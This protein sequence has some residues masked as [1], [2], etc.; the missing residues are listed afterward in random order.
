MLLEKIKIIF[1]DVTDVY[2]MKKILKI[3]T[4]SLLLSFI[5]AFRATDTIIEKL[6]S[7]IFGLFSIL[8][9]VEIAFFGLFFAESIVNRKAKEFIVNKEE[10]I[11]YYQ[12]LVTKNFYSISL[13]MTNI[14]VIYI[15]QIFDLKFSVHDTVITFL[16]K[17]FPIKLGAY[18]FFYFLS[19]YTLIVMVDLI[20]TIYFYLWK[21]EKQP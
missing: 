17:V 20:V 11:T 9:V 8:I 10:N 14:V 7:S 4:L 15:L 19:I 12:T 16:G 3:T 2:G 1:R 6:Y 13:K 21:N 18:L 5:G